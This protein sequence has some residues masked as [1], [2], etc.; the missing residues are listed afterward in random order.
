M[1]VG[2]GQAA[3]LPSRRQSTSVGFHPTSSA[4]KA[5]LLLQQKAV[6]HHSSTTVPGGTPL[7]RILTAFNKALA[8][9]KPNPPAIIIDEANK[10]TSWSTDYPKELDS[11]L[12]FFVAVTKQENLT[13]VLLLTSDYGYVNWLEQGIGKTFY[14]VQVIGD[15]PVKEA[16][17]FYSTRVP[18]PVSDEDWEQVY[19]VCGGNAGLLIRAAK[20]DLQKALTDIIT[21]VRPSVERGLEPSIDAGFTAQQQVLQAMVRENLL[22]YRPYSTWAIDIHTDAFGPKRKEVVTAPTPAHLH[23]MRELELPD[24][25]AADTGAG[26]AFSDPETAAVRKAITDVEGEI[27]DVKTEIDDIKKDLKTAQARSDTQEVQQLRDELR[28]LRNKE[29][30]LR[31]VLK[32][33]LDKELLLMQS[34]ASAA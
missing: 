27:S 23:C 2:Q 26:S 1:L 14:N 7:A 24:E 30:Q 12:S 28:Q 4:R 13:H 10:F 11:L 34:E 17:A 32:K 33:R 15:F 20:A 5:C 3:Q 16:R 6:L 25:P 22:A 9:K 21:T 18:G 8:A 29:S 19:Q 31:E